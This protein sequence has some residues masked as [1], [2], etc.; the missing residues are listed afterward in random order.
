[1]VTIHEVAA[2]AGV[3]TATVSRALNGKSS[4]DPAL[5]ERVREAARELGYQRNALARGLRRRKTAQWALV[6]AD[7][8]NPFFTAMARGVEDVAQAAGYSVLL[9]NSDENRAKERQY[10]DVAV[11]DRVAGVILA[12][13]STETDASLLAEHEI[14]VVA[15]DRPLRHTPADTVLVGS[16]EGARTAA[17]HLLASGYRRLGC[18][19]GPAGVQTAD[20]RLAGYYDALAVA[21]LPRPGPGEDDPRVRRCDFKVA[22][23]RAAGA[24]L[25]DGPDRPDAL[26]VASGLMVLGVLQAM[27]ERGLRAGRDVGLV[28]FDDTPWTPLLDPPLSVIAQPAREVGRVAARLLLDR[29][30]SGQEKRPARTVT[31]GTELVV[32]ASSRRAP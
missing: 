17:E 15:I 9:C 31:L 1:M 2:R 27:R 13:T 28:A 22:G 3:S 19:T 5:A 32:R 12:P 8:E 14:P 20:E 4:V 24:A 29:L 23:A 26:F 30:R 21:G 16:R 10:L 25:L 6:I 18:V 7:I 11:Q